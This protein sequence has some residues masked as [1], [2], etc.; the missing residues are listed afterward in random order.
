[1][2]VDFRFVSLAFLCV[3]VCVCAGEDPQVGGAEQGAH[4]QLPRHVRRTQSRTGQSPHGQGEV[5]FE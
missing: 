4:L 2:K 3:C 5:K 1:M